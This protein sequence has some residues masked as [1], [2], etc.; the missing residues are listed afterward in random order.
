MAIWPTLPGFAGTFG[1]T[2]VSHGWMHLFYISWLF[3]LV[4]SSRIYGTLV[5]FFPPSN[6]QAPKA[7]SFES[8]A[9]DQRALLDGEVTV[10]QATEAQFGEKG[11]EEEMKKR[12]KGDGVAAEVVPA[13]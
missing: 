6:M 7:S 13:L 4:A 1:T 11:E 9:D 3:A 2:K 5:L 12:E 8:W 10:E